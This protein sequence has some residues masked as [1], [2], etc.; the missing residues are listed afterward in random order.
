MENMYIFLFLV[1]LSANVF[2]ITLFKGQRLLWNTKKGNF[3]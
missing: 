3:D 1:F 2:G